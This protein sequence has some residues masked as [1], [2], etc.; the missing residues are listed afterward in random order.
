MDIDL[1][2]GLA[3][4]VPLIAPLAA[5][6]FHIATGSRL[7]RDAE[8]TRGVKREMISRCYNR[9]AHIICPHRFSDAQ[10]GFKAL[11]RAA[12]QELLPLVENNHWF[13][14]TELLLMAEEQGYD[15]HEVPVRWV[16]DID[17]RVHIARTAK[18]DIAGLMR[19]RDQR[20]QR[21]FGHMPRRPT[22]TPVRE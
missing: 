9:L 18:E 19:V 6:Q 3:A 22:T 10:C 12:A 15:I 2:T 14:D 13:F 16:E 17:S 1:S 5:G 7:L 11:S 21:R 4:F 8:V 20:W